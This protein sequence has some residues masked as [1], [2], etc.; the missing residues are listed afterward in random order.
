MTHGMRSV[1]IA[2]H[3]PSLYMPRLPIVSKY[4]CVRNSGAFASANVGAIDVP[5]IGSCSI[6][7]TVCGCGMPA[8]SRIV[9]AMSITW[10]NCERKPPVSVMRSGQRTTMGLRVPPR[11]EPTCLPHWNGVFPAHAHAAP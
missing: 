11:W 1:F 2:S 8:R 3:Q 7:S 5:C 9:G 10:P 4:C 6:P